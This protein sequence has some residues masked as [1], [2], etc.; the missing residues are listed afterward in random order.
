[1]SAGGL[2]D[3]SDLCR[4]LRRAEASWAAESAMTASITA[5]MRGWLTSRPPTRVARRPLRKG[6]I[7]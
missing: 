3:F 2:Q 6:A 7:S 4:K 1:V 5:R